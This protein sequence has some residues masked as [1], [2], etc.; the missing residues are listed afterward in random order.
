MRTRSL[1][2]QFSQGL[3]LGLLRIILMELVK[4]AK[5]TLAEIFELNSALKLF[6]LI[7]TSLVVF[8]ILLCNSVIVFV[9]VSIPFF[10]FLRSV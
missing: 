4:N 5:S 8:E 9:A 2:S 7:D 10:K 1:D 6:R 3:I